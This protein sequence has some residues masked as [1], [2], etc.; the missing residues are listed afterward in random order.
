MRGRLR[1]IA[2]NLGLAGVGLVLALLMAEMTLRL[3]GYE[4][5]VFIVW[6]EDFGVLSI[7]GARGTYKDE[8]RAVV[9]I[10]SQGFRDIERRTD[11]PANTFRI[12]VL[13][14]S[15]IEA[16]EVDRR[17]TL[18]AVLERRLSGCGALNAQRVEV[19]N[20]GVRSFGPAQELL[21]L[22]ERVLQY[23]PDIVLL[24]FYPGNDVLNAS[25][26]LDGDPFK[27][28]FSLK[29]GALLLDASYRARV[30]AQMGWTNRFWYY[31]A[32][33]NSRFAQLVHEARKSVIASVAGA[34]LPAVAANE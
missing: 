9:E 16:I 5:P 28:Y 6:Q 12:A 33:Q 26:S 27:P 15:F 24:A 30:R 34:G 29:D 7:P 10:N 19:L 11:K 25:R 31:I 17:D 18:P 14:D 20:F 13:G 32:L 23:Q 1:A 21:L 2:I 22:K 4:K 3:I 8:G